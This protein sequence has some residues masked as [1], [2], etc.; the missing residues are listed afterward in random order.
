MAPTLSDVRV[1]G[2]LEAIETAARQLGI[3]MVPKQEA[4]R[5]G[6][7]RAA[8]HACSERR[9]APCWCCLPP[10]SP[11]MRRRLLR[12]PRRAASLRCTSTRISWNPGGLISYGPS[13][14]D[15]FRR[16]A[17]YTDRILKGSV[18]ADLPVEQA[19][20]LDLVVNVKAARALGLSFPQPLLGRASRVIE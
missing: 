14:R 11:R 4:R 10:S 12:W 17:G 15:I 1:P 3:Q 2:N 9:R 18:P 13:P 19:D 7:L 5:P 6:D 16:V 8:S 20:K